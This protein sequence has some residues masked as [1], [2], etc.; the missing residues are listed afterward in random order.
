MVLTTQLERDH[1]TI[2]DITYKDNI[3]GDPKN[4]PPNYQIIL[5]ATVRFSTP[6]LDWLSNEAIWVP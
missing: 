4:P 6:C 3:Q 2:E 1:I 5:G